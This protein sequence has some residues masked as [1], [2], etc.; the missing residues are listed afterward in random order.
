MEAPLGQELPQEACSSENEVYACLLDVPNSSPG[1]DGLSVNTPK[2]VW[3]SPTWRT[4]IILLFSA[5][6]IHGTH[7]ATFKTA[8]VVMIPK[9]HKEDMSDTANWRPISLLPCLGKGLER[10]MARRL[11]N[12]ALPNRIIPPQLLGGLK[13]RSTEDIIRCLI[14]D[15][16]KAWNEGKVATLI[17]MD[18]KS[19]Y[20][21]VLPGR[22]A[23]RL[24]EQ[25]WPLWV[26]RWVANFAAGR[27]AAIRIDSFLSE[28][29]SLQHGL[30]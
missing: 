21:S 15:I 7:P 4:W 28:P 5:C 26:C 10:L 29:R 2:T 1:I 22:L 27:K 25:G 24:Q 14:N 30:P 3:Q 19:A 6:I 13:A 23:R 20:D 12:C 18:I 8:E 16:E 11:I 17:T 9:P